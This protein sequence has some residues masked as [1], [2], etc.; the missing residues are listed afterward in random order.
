[1]GEKRR[2]VMVTVGGACLGGGGVDAEALA[3][4]GADRAAAEVGAVG[5]RWG[6]GQGLVERGKRRAGEG[7]CAT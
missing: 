5:L 4:A 6:S 1:L 3:A 7:E 2:R